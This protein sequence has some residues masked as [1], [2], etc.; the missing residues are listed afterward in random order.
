MVK[1]LNMNQHVKNSVIMH[2]ERLDGTGYPYRLNELT[3][4][5]YARYMA[6][7]DAYVAMASPRSYRSAFTPLSILA[8]FEKA[9]KEFATKYVLNNGGDKEWNEWL[10]KAETL[11]YKELV[12]VYNDAQKR[13]DS[14][15]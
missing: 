2:H 6:I 8:D 12:K 15:S 4:D 10:K 13:F 1:N 5:K 9:G 11:G 14:K 7:I 3:I